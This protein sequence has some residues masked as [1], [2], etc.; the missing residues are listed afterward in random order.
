[1]CM[2]TLFNVIIRRLHKQHGY[3]CRNVKADCVG[4]NPDFPIFL[5]TWGSDSASL[6]L[7]SFSPKMNTII[8]CSLGS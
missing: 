8:V 7:S 6:N 4:S 2:L 5:Q 3:E 1:M